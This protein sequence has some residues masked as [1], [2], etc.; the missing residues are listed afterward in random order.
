MFKIIFHDIGCMPDETYGG[1]SYI[2]Q[3]EKYAVLNDEEPKL[4]KSEKVARNAAEK[5][6]AS[7]VNTGVSYSI[8]E[9]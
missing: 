3:G 5:L 4:F 8:E 6:L 2:F 1:G 7:C 9:V